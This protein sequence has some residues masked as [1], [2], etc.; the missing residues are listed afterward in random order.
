MVTVLQYN[1]KIN[2][3]V[4]SYNVYLLK[5]LINANVSP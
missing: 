2:V 4:L 3:K 5:L 1:I